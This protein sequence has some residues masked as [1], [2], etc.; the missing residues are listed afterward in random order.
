MICEMRYL[1][2]LIIFALGKILSFENFQRGYTI[3][4]A[5]MF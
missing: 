4:M 3:I 2:T 5:V 1:L